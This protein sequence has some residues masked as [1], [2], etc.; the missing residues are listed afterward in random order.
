VR[1]SAW[2]QQPQCTGQH[3]RGQ[4]VTRRGCA[5]VYTVP[6]VLKIVSKIGGGGLRWGGVFLERTQIL[7]GI[8]FTRHFIEFVVVE[9]KQFVSSNVNVILT[10]QTCGQHHDVCG[11]RKPS[12]SILLLRTYLPYVP[13]IKV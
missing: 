2:R 5:R 11:K 13:N 12:A 3:E 7:S 8:Q 1:A 9:T 6:L 10:R 4:H